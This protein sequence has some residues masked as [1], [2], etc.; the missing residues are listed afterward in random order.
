M[1]RFVDR[2]PVSQH[3]IVAP[4]DVVLLDYGD[5][6]MQMVRITPSREYSAEGYV[7]GSSRD[8]FDYGNRA[9]VISFQVAYDCGDVISALLDQLNRTKNL[10]AGGVDVTI[11]LQGV[12]GMLTLKK[13]TITAAASDTFHRFSI[14]NYTLTGGAL[15]GDDLSIVEIGT[16]DGGVLGTEDGGVL[17]AE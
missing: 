12:S 5:F 13:A 4:G 17:T 15:T 9:H 3:R 1:D 2:L 16:E 11:Q 6:L 14:F 10:P 8:T 7:Q